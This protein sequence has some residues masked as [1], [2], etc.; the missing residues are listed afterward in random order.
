MQCKVII[1]VYFQVKAKAV[2]LTLENDLT[3]K[4]PATL[5]KQHKDW[6][7]FLDEDAASMVDKKLI[8]R[9]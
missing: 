4:I 8:E 9:Y 5:L 3:N 2:K 1:P 6:T 7:L